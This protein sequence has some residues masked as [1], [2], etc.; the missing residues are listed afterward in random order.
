M[1]RYDRDIRNQTYVLRGV[2]FEVINN[3]QKSV[4]QSY[5]KLTID[6]IIKGIF[7]SYM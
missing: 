5:T 2:T 7:E 6:K 1:T 4:N 3:L